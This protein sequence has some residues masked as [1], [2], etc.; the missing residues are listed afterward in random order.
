MMDLVIRASEPLVFRDG[1]PFGESGM[2][3]GGML[4]WPMPSTLAGFLRTRVG[5][6]RDS[7]FFDG[8]DA[9]KLEKSL[10]DI[11]SVGVGCALPVWRFTGEAAWKVLY[12]K[13]ADSVVVDGEKEGSLRLL[14]FQ[15]QEVGE[16]EG[17]NAPFGD[18]MVPVPPSKNKP[19]LRQP[20]IWTGTV[21]RDWLAGKI[22]GELTRQELGMDFPARETRIHSSIE[23]GTGTVAEGKLFA[24]HGIRL[25]AKDPLGERYLEYGIA[26]QVLGLGQG[27]RPTG[28]GHLGGERRV[29]WMEPYA[30]DSLLPELPPCKG[31]RFLRLVLLTPGKFGDW[32]PSWLIPDGWGVPVAPWVRVPHSSL[33]VRLRSAFIPRWQPVSGWDYVQKGPKAMHKLVP[34]GSVYILEVK[35]PGQTEELAR[36]LQGR[37]LGTDREGKPL[38]GV[39]EGYGV[40][41]VGIADAM[42]RA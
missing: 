4:P 20:Q 23:P 11:L 34:A 12:P 33:E 32:A 5:L 18:W 10:E 30:G 15:L 9:R 22:P 24:S 38:E 17:C 7:H 16:N 1:R 37:S 13:P 42:Y 40:A 29:A 28:W 21:F 25:M 3:S 26:V 19:S 35:D 27:E 2:F 36:L 41:A 8:E 14:P 39:L 31:A 6:A